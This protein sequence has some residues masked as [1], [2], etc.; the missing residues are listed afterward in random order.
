MSNTIPVGIARPIEECST[1][2]FWGPISA[3]DTGLCRRYPPILAPDSKTG[4][5][6]PQWPWTES[7]EWCGEWHPPGL[8]VKP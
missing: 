7:E 4:A 8:A 2:R 6:V 1:C 3:F 5:F